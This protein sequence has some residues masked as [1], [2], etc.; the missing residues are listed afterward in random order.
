MHESSETRWLL[1]DDKDCLERELAGGHSMFERKGRRELEDRPRC[2]ICP[3][4]AFPKAVVYL[5]KI[6]FIGPRVG[7]AAYDTGHMVVS[8]RFRELWGNSD[9][10]GLEFSPEPI[11]FTGKRKAT[12][13]DPSREYFLAIPEPR[14]T[15]FVDT[16]EAVYTR[17]PPCQVCSASEVNRLSKLAFQPATLDATDFCLPSCLPGWR[18]VSSRFREFIETHRLMN[19]YFME[20]FQ[21]LEDRR[22]IR[23]GYWWQRSDGSHERFDVISEDQLGKIRAEQS[24]CSCRAK[25]GTLG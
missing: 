25:L 10:A 21:R 23:S 3:R 2:P 6:R 1:L 4:F 12:Y 13:T 7:D 19:F 22:L 24:R 17:Q 18:L 14:V 15:Q 11:P 16:A 5:E 8:R 9:L 20:A